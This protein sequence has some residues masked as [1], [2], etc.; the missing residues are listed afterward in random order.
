MSR[1]RPS[2]RVTGFVLSLLFFFIPAAV[3]Q[4]QNGQITGVITDPSGAVLAQALVRIR[5]PA[6]G[7]AVEAETNSSGVYAATE[8]PVGTYL[9]GVEIPGFKTVTAKNLDLN[10]GTILRVDFKLELGSRS[11]K[12]EVIDAARTVNTESSRLSYTV[13]S[14]QIDNL[15]LNGRSVYNFI[16][17][18]PGAINVRGL[19][20]E[21]GADTVV[22]GVR[23]SFNG[24][25]ING[26]TNTG[27][28]G[29]PVNQP[30]QDTVEEIQLLTVNNSAEFGSSAGAITDVVTKAGTNNLHGSAWEFLQNDLLDAN[31]FFTNKFAD[32]TNPAKS[33][34]H[35]NQFGA[36]SGGPILKD[37]LFFFA[38][39]QLER[40]TTTSPGQAKAESPAFRLATISAFP[41]S[42]AALLYANFPPAGKPVPL[43]TL[44]QSM[45]MGFDHFLTFADYL[46]P[47]ETDGKTAMAGSISHKFATLFGVEQAD[48]NEMNANCPGG[49]PYSSPVAGTFSRDADFL[50]LVASPGKSQSQ[51]DLFNGNEGS[52]RIDYN[53]GARNRIFSQFNWANSG[54]RYSNFTSR[55]FSSPSSLLTPNFQFTYIHLF[56]P[57]MINDFRAGYARNASTIAVPLP[58]VPSVVTDVVGFG[59]DEGAPQSFRENIY[60][61]SDA[62]S[63]RRGN[64]GLRVGAELRRNVENSDFNAGRP[65]YLFYDSLFFAIDAPFSEDVGVDPGFRADAP[66]QLA[67]NIRH[68][69]NWD[70]GAY[71]RDD[72]KVSRRLTVNLGLRYDIFTRSKELD[73]LATTFIRGPGYQPVDNITTGAGQIKDASTPCPGDPR[74]TLAGECGPGGFAPA[75][76]LGKADHNNFGPRIGFAW[77]A[78]GDG[79]TSLRGSLGIAYEGA[80]QKRL[81]LTRWNP[82]YYSLNRVYNYLDGDPNSVIY[83]PVDGGQP[84]FSGPAPLAQHSG[85]GEQ[86]TGNISGWNPS[87]PQTS[88]YTSIVFSDGL[89]DPFIENWFLGVQREILPKFTLEIN[90]VATA[91][92][93]LYR[94]DNVNRVPGAR[95]PEGTCVTDN[96]GRR[97]CSQINSGTAPN[98]LSINPTGRFLNPNFGVLRVWENSASSIYHSLQVSARKRMDHGLQLSVNYTYS[99]SIDDGS[100][101]QSGSD[102]VNGNAAGDAYSTDQTQPSLDRGDSVFDIR[103][104]LTFNYVWQIPFFNNS[105]GVHASILTGWQLNGLWSFQG[106]A[107][108]SPFSA[109]QPKLEDRPGFPGACNP[110][111][112][113]P[114]DCINTGGDFNLD[115]TT[116]DRPNALANNVHATH[117]QWANGFNL[118]ANFFSAPCLAC[119][120]N[121]GRNTF[122][123]PGYWSADVSL[124]KNFLLKEKFRLQFRAE[125]FNVFNHTNFLIGGNN[126]LRNPSFGAASGT[127]PPR[128]LQFGVKMAY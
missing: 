87:N 109:D 88:N 40:F 14:V 26:I 1:L 25:R 29:G 15:P 86:A 63:A 50:D 105:A 28:S 10:A 7:F 34:L 74:A 27:L 77:D 32:P 123:G 4:V 64:H 43:L 120:G 125:A 118:P 127:A 24:F 23:E 84:T 99:H 91:G 65:G 95:L 30:I 19:M 117:S 41:I 6:T 69:R 36:T 70:I 42:V 2:C 110:A 21:N 121:L 11:E 62:V 17:Y 31:P 71:L 102:S 122:V 128:N 94:A 46:C 106:G 55:G 56:S 103:H 38:A 124:V 83:G 54:D 16:Q 98:G 60:N 5:N 107:H 13:D 61:Y 96:M 100:T 68:W 67:T 12:I 80:L 112:F 53:S 85:T 97:L 52:L 108:W 66:A 44:R 82:P 49:S 113:D 9:I 48:I 126:N 119:A 116:N 78:L 59:T 58:G 33:P 20:F 79:K 115:G 73:G 90:Y 111:T 39:F 101:W 37:K 22:N 47:R 93:N 35:L 57:T 18:Q 75:V 81:S 72:W 89:P 51:G 76:N 8:L 104:R 3:A 114:A 45:D 92:R